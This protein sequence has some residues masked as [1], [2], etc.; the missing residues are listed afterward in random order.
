MN[1]EEMKRL[2]LT[3]GLLLSM[4]GAFSQETQRALPDSL[5]ACLQ[6]EQGQ[7]CARVQASALVTSVSTASFADGLYL[8]K[9]TSNDGSVTNQ[10]I[11]VEH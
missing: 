4:I 8:L 7:N 11:V 10:R 5:V 1:I 2:L 3:L 6:E 9:V